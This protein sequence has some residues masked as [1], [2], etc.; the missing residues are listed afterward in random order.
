MDDVYSQNPKDPDDVLKIKRSVSLDKF[1]GFGRKF[2]V[3]RKRLASPTRRLTT[4]PGGI[5]DRAQQL[6]P[7]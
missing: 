5:I 2:D 7:P 6:M 4:A 3:N 1:T